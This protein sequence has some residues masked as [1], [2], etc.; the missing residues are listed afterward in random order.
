MHQLE[1]KVRIWDTV[2]SRHGINYI[3]IRIETP[4]PILELELVFSKV[5]GIG[6][7]VIGVFKCF[8]VTFTIT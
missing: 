5:T 2:G 7:N 8:S 3:V 1:E 4:I 6:E